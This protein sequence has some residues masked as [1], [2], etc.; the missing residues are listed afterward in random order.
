MS[1]NTN[2][3]TPAIVLH[4]HLYQLNRLNE[5]G[6]CEITLFGFLFIW[7]FVGCRSHALVVV[8]RCRCECMR[9]H[10]QAVVSHMCVYAMHKN[11][12]CC[13]LFFF[14]RA[15]PVLMEESDV[16][17]SACSWCHR[18]NS[19]KLNVSSFCNRKKVLCTAWKFLPQQNYVFILTVAKFLLILIVNIFTFLSLQCFLSGLFRRISTQCNLI[20]CSFNWVSLGPRKLTYSQN[21]HF[22]ENAT[23]RSGQKI[24]S[25]LLYGQKMMKTR[26]E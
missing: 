4:R 1:E 15:H 12:Q 7:H 21:L 26:S 10:T 5:S 11:V 25:W 17:V 14:F 22:K 23:G 8:E 13:Q 3:C 20:I 16:T 24:S 6:R 19:N 2:N 9:A 18:W